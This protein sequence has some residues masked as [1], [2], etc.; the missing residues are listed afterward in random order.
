M[1]CV[2]ADLLQEVRTQLLVAPE[3]EQEV[4]S[5]SIPGMDRMQA[6]RWQFAPAVAEAVAV[7]A[8]AMVG[9]LVVGAGVE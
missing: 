3:P 4:R 9:R 6:E 7:A 1:S 5:C 8:D 2:S